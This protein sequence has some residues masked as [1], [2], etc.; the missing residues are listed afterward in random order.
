MSQPGLKT[1]I[2]SGVILI[3]WWPELARQHSPGWEQPMQPLAYITI[4][5]ACKGQIIPRA[6]LKHFNSDLVFW[7]TEDK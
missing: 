7:D 5:K 4:L 3:V 2:D 6:T 1:F